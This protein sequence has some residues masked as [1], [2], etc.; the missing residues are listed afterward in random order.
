ML[1]WPASP[2]ARRLRTYK[3]FVQQ[4]EDLEKQYVGGY[5]LA[6]APEEAEAHDDYP[7]SLAIACVLTEATAMPTAEVSANP[8]NQ[9][10]RRRGRR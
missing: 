3:R 6:A 10:R 5:L 7:D 8:F 9:H 4:M 2:T 1:S